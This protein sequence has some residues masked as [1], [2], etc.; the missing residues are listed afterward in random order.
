MIFCR[1]FIDR[2]VATTLLALAIFLSGLI[3][4]P[5]LPISTMPDMTATSIMVVANQPGA[6]PQQMATS[7]STPLE[8]R[9]ASIADVQSLE[10]VTSSGQ[11]SI[12]MDFSSSRDI[13]GALRDVQAALRA[14]RSDLPAGTLTSDPQAFKLD[15]DRPIYLLHLTSDQILRPK[16]YD[17]AAIRV[18]PALAQIPGVGR[19]EIFGSSNPAVRVELN[20]YPLYRWGLNPEDI[21]SALASANAFTP[22][23]FIS[24]GN[25]RIQL[26]T[27]DQA[28]DAAH[29][30]DLIVAYRNGGNP[31]FLK[32]VA[33]VRDDVQDVY[34]NSTLNGQAAI[35]LA[36]I[37]QPHANAVHIVDD[38]IKRIP[39]I[40]QAIPTSVEL[41]TGLDLSMTIRASL[42]DAKATLVIS[43]ILVVMVVAIFFRH[44]T[45]TLIPTITI[46]V[47]L[48]GT[49]TAMAW[50]NF[51]LD[52]LSL[53]ALT[54]AVGF[55]IDDAIVVLENIARHIEEGMDRHQAS[56]V[57]TSEIAFT[58]VSISLS[59]I[60]VFIPLLYIPGTLGSALQ[61]FALTMTATIAISMILSLTLTPALCARFLT[62]KPKNHTQ[63]KLTPPHKS[64]ATA[65][66]HW[67]FFS[68]KEIVRFIEDGL[69]QLTITYERSLR[70]SLRH[71]ILIGLTL[72]SSFVLMVGG[73]ILMPKTAIPEMDLAI[74][75]GSISGEPNLSFKA[76]TRRIH[77]VGDIV[78][79][80]PAVQTV[81]TFNRD[82]HKG[83]FFITLKDKSIRSD[84]S[85]VLNRLRKAIPQ[86]AGGETFFWALDHTRKG[87]DD[88]N[89]TG[90]YRYVLQSDDSTPLYTTMPQLL[91]KLRASG[92]FLNL[93]TDAEELS[94]A[95]NIVIRRD[96]EARYNITPQLVQNALFDAYGQ[97]IV[98]IIHLPLTEHRVVMVV[99]EPFREYPN[100][101]HHLWL[102]TSAGTAAGGI[103]SNLIRVRTNTTLSSQASLSRDSVTNSL[104]NQLSGNNS[105]GA[106]VSSSQE[107]M[108]PLD[109]VA[110]VVNTPL[111][112]RISHHNGYY[113]TTLSFDLADGTNYDDAI[114]LINN[115]LA[116]LHASDSI[117]GEFTGT[118]GETNALMVNA[119]LAFL[120]AITVMYI[121]LGILYESLIHPVTILSTLPSAGV[122]GILGLW[123]TGE[124]FS[125]V[126]IIGVILLTGLVKKNAILVIDFALHIHHHHPDMTAEDAIHHASVTRFRP[127]LMTTLAAALG[128]IPLLT[129]RGYGCE[130]RHP[131][132]IAILGGMAVSQLLTFYT[133]PAVY[134][135]MEGLKRRCLNL[136]GRIRA[137]L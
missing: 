69:S 127:I 118:A 93:S 82:N 36:V 55:V 123:T 44:F 120:A 57:G 103:A 128:S 72:P 19:I 35:T 22:K 30:R 68:L 8:R 85:T 7:V 12:F 9:L 52:I 73:L 80:D 79:H 112:L 4:L 104:A 107:T 106:A 21:R 83:R 126:A 133:T 132:G 62:I 23:G 136:G 29:Y 56:I 81:I 124:E 15:G 77:Q 48:S 74:L 16:L 87:G 49:L 119:L 97:S 88:S 17:L 108:I 5:F 25:Q 1:L 121:T 61:E 42:V 67:L 58:I 95:A 130:L 33:T 116:S 40:R 110:N 111:P 115:A 45:S 84:I 54:I 41:R 91:T 122:G 135:L 129:S 71:P 78:Q 60:A 37:P 99:A 13:D 28:V 6:D 26:Q 117:H 34:Q 2:P 27:N 24:T 76:L 46:P 10:S 100:T 75:Q 109:N 131:L 101:L 134:L 18:R 114:A 113:A 66:L 90:N 98:S 96:L 47:A 43:I 137:A 102:S 32:D 50:F 3:A 20:P 39:Q 38:I 86:Q 53:M 105:N 65:P 59:L 94:V 31:I 14:A 70:W 51:S 63:K 92:K 89:T 125:L 11:T 64:F